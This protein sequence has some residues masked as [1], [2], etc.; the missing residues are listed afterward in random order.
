M[1]PAAVIYDA[2]LTLS[3]PVG[4]SVASGLNGLAHCVDGMW[5]PRADPINQALGA[6]GIRALARGLPLIAGDPSGI[7]GRELALYGAYLS[8]VAFASA[9]SGLHHKICHVLGGTY[10]LP[11]AETHATVLPYVLAFNAPA[12]P[13]AAGRIAHALGSDSGTAEAAVAALDELRVRLHAPT[14]LRDYGLTEADLPGAVERVLAV[15]P[16]S[17]PRPVTGNNLT[18][19]LRAA[20]TG[21]A[22]ATQLE[23]I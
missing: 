2:E 13:E 4:L 22:P 7:E 20:L 11:H 12:A 23:E 10:E 18:A 14:A 19:L 9:G 21:A 8:A 1:L 3:L 16:P 15:V 5:A 17:N 6:E